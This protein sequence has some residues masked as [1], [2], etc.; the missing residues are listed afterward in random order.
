MA[1]FNYREIDETDPSA[2]QGEA[3]VQEQAIKAIVASPN[4]LDTLKNLVFFFVANDRGFEGLGPDAA[5]VDD[6]LS[7]HGLELPEPWLKSLITTASEEMEHRHHPFRCVTLKVCPSF[8]VGDIRGS[9]FPW[10][11]NFTLECAVECCHLHVVHSR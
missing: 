4:W 3:A 8:R 7:A 5:R 10:W 1:A 6:L 2:L 9:H 11:S